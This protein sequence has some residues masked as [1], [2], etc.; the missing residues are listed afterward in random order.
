MCIENFEIRKMTESDREKVL[1]LAM[2]FFRGEALA[3]PVPT[4]II[5][6]TLNSAIDG[7]KGLDGYTFTENGEVIGFAYVT[8]YFSTERGGTCVQIEDIC[9]SEKC[10]GKGY[11]T[12]FFRWLEEQRPYAKRF[13]LEVTDVNVPAQKLYKRLGFSEVGYI[14]MAM[15]V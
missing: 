2:S 14:Q 12:K 11:G 5:N 9:L 10:R 6:V 8:E 13:R 7:T 3:H 1:N 15:E 4:D